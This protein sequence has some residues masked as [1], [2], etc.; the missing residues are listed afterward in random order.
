MRAKVT[1]TQ[2]YFAIYQCKKGILFKLKATKTVDFMHE[3]KDKRLSFLS[4]WDISLEST[5]STEI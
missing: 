5:G 3:P 4:K 2:L 1:K